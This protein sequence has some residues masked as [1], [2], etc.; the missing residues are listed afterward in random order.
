[1]SNKNYLSFLFIL[2]IT[3]MLTSCYPGGPEYIDE[4]DL[5]GTRYDKSFDFSKVDTYMLPD[6]IVRL[7]DPDNPDNNLP[8]NSDFDDDILD[9][10]KQNMDGLGYEYQPDTN[11]G[12]PDIVLTVSAVSTRNA[13]YYWYYWYDY[14]GWWGY[15]PPYY[16]P[17]WGGYYPWGS[18]LMYSY[19]TGTLIISMIDVESY[20]PDEE[21]ATIR[22]NA[23]IN[24][25]LE[26]SDQYI[27]NRIERGINQ[28][29]SQSAY[30][31][32]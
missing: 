23:S 21:E 3:I 32:K 16:G 7:D 25:V 13:G 30:L 5:V 31:K 22:W 18:V 1:M 8:S 4:M 24:G 2:T 28:A 11:Q 6:S 9:L 29:F 20:D 17:G 15:W 14:W 10:I 27:L 19:T 12:Y 26:G